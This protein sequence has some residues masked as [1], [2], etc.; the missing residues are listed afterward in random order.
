MWFIILEKEYICEMKIKKIFI[1]IL[2]INFS[3]SDYRKLFKTE[4]YEKKLEAALN[5]YEKEGGSIRM[6][7]S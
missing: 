5:Y 2:F 4:G 7:I 3:C 6:N 1:I